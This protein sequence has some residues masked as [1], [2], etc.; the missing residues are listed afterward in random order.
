MVPLTSAQSN[1]HEEEDTL[2]D[3]HSQKVEV[4]E[5]GQS[6][7]WIDTWLFESL[8]LAFSVACFIAICVILWVYDK[9]VW[10]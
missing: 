8:T 10:L 7:I 5:I 6:S 4:Q 3:D 1:N 9:K 2:S